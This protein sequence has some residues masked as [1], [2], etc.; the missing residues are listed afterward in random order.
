MKLS[1]REQLLQLQKKRFHQTELSS[2][3]EFYALLVDGDRPQEEREVNPTQMKLFL[4]TDVVRAYKGPAGCAK[5]STIVADMLAH[6]LIEPGSKH[7]CGRQDYN[8][9]MATTVIRAEEMIR[10]LPAGTLLDRTKAPPMSWWLKPIPRRMPDGTVDETPS[11]ITFMGMKDIFKGSYEFSGGILDEADEMEKNAVLGLISRLRYTKGTRYMDLAFNPPSEDHW[12]YTACT[13]LNTYG[14]KVEEPTMTLFEPQPKENVRNL[15]PGYYELLTERL[16]EDMRQRL[17][18]GAWGSTFPGEPAVKQ[19]KRNIHVR[20]VIYG[21]GTVFRFW[22]FGFNRPFC[23]WAQVTKTGRLAVM[24]ELLGHKQEVKPFAA[25]VHRITRE[26]FPDAQAFVDYGDPAV[27][28][29]KDTGSALTQFRECGIILR[30]QHTP[31]DQ[32]LRTLRHR[33]EALIEGEPAITVAP[34]C[35]ILIAALGGGYHFDKDGV[36]PKKDGYYDH[37]VDALRYGVWNMWGSTTSLSTTSMVTSIAYWSANERH[38]QR[39]PGGADDQRGPRIPLR[40]SGP[41]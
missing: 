10:R 4:S 5:T 32:S 7:F 18:D 37:P 1:A 20:P 36:T 21:G 38:L 29:H 34:K 17:V 15:I 28:Q 35:K 24:A 25:D 8:D 14:E 12:L 40:G 3:K 26:L 30:Y 33:F 13:G 6:A 16:P 31:F 39:S 27:K 22:D 2:W 41:R 9:L 23:C 19:F 11:Q